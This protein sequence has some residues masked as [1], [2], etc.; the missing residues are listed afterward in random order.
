[1]E[2]WKM[3]KCFEFNTRPGGVVEVRHYDEPIYILNETHRDLVSPLFCEIRVRYPE[4]YADLCCRYK[5]SIQNTRYFELK[6]VCG[7]IKCNWGTFDGRYDIDE[8][9][10]WHLEYHI[11]PMSGDCKSENRV[12]NPT[13]KLPLTDSEVRIVKLIAIGKKVCEISERLFV[14]PKTVEAHV[15]N[16]HKKLGT[17]SNAQLSNYAHRK[18]LIH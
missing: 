17:D 5:D 3:L 11:C 13:E 8:N 15:Y 4:A 7:F 2:T 10:D 12:C 16:I 18:N 14:A 6:V 1:M 9:G